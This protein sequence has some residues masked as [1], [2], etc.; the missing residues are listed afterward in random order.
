MQ[1]SN[2]VLHIKFSSFMFA[3]FKIWKLETRKLETRCNCYT[4]LMKSRTRHLSFA[5]LAIVISSS[6]VVVTSMSYLR[7]MLIEVQQ[8]QGIE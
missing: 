8:E 4:R 6:V 5:L 1:N 3:S 2:E 7:A